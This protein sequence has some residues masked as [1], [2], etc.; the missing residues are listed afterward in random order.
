VVKSHLPE[1]IIGWRCDGGSFLRLILF[2]LVAH[3]L[4]PGVVGS[5]AVMGYMVPQPFVA[6]VLGRNRRSMVPGDISPTVAPE[7][8]VE[9]VTRAGHS[10]VGGT[11]THMVLCALPWDSAVG[12]WG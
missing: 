10:T 4:Q 8:S 5:F 1:L 3:P 12:L 9:Q 2:R 11:G 6:R 7:P